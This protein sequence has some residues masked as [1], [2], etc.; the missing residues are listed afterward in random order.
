MED[1]NN[2]IDAKEEKIEFVFERHKVFSS[3]NK[4]PRTEQEQ[5]KESKKM[6]FIHHHVFNSG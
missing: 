5:G 2:N 4:D 3:F 1:D 6:A